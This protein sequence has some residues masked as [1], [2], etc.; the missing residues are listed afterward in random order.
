MFFKKVV[1]NAAYEYKPSS[2]L[3]SREHMRIW[4]LGTYNK[5]PVYAISATKS[6]GFDFYLDKSF[7]VPL[8]GLDANVDKSRTFFINTFKTINPNIKVQMLKSRLGPKILSFDSDGE[9][10]SLYYTDGKIAE[11]IVP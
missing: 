8:H 2:T 3:L 1:Q 5:I 11:I 9:S 6:T 4:N 10:E 7:I